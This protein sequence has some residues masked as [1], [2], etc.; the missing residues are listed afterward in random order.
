ME[1]VKEIK[2]QLTD[3]T[4]AL[5]YGRNAAINYHNMVT[6]E[7]GNETI[8]NEFT[9]GLALRYKDMDT[10]NDSSNSDTYLIYINDDI[11]NFNDIC[12]VLVHEISHVVDFTMEYMETNDTEYRAHLTSYLYAEFTSYLRVKHTEPE[13]ITSFNSENLNKDNTE[14]GSNE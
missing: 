13:D 9:L 3:I 5:C 12:K 2:L 8:A 14:G 7:D 6:G 1:N 10:V 4:V 11:V